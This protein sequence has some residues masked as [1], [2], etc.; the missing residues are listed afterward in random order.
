[1]HPLSTLD[2]RNWRKRQLLEAWIDTPPLQIMFDAG[3]PDV[4]MR[5][6]KRDSYEMRLALHSVGLIDEN[7]FQV[8]IYY[9]G[10][11]ERDL[12]TIPWAAVH[13]IVNSQ[14]FETHFWAQDHDL[15]EARYRMQH[16]QT[17][18]LH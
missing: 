9:E 15:A 16:S 13:A 14:L 3:H 11:M 7:G 18:G 17:R 10:E 5:K 12:A 4:V 1:M 2:E 6:D 8:S